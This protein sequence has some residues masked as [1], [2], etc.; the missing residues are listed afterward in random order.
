MN[1]IKVLLMCL[2]VSIISSCSKPSDRG[3]SQTDTYIYENKSGYN[4]KLFYYK[5]LK[6]TDINIVNNESYTEKVV[7]KLPLTAV[8]PCI[9]FSDSVRVV[10]SDGKTLLYRR[11]T[12]SNSDIYIRHAQV[13]VQGKNIT[14]K[15]V[16]TQEDYNKAE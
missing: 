3:K 12:E 8:D 10:Y 13:S 5:D 15:F 7:L 1:Y 11:L 14:Y 16:F 2:F 4:L 9:R 6:K